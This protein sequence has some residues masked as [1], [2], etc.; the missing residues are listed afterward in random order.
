MLLS[1]RTTVTQRAPSPV[2]TEVQRNFDLHQCQIVSTGAALSGDFMFFVTGFGE[3][4]AIPVGFSFENRGER[5]DQQKTPRT[6]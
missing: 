3:E 2:L 5:N 6:R 4:R 1:L